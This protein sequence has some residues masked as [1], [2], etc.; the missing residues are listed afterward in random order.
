MSFWSLIDDPARSTFDLENNALALQNQ[1]VV[2]LYT[3]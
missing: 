2:I 3:I 1:V